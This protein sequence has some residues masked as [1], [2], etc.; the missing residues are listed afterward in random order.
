MDNQVWFDGKVHWNGYAGGRRIMST[1]KKVFMS[2]RKVKKDYGYRNLKGRKNTLDWR[3]KYPLRWFEWLM[4]PASQKS[5]KHFRPFDVTRK[6]FYYACSRI[7]GFSRRKNIYV[8]SI[9]IKR[10]TDP[11][12]E[13]LSRQQTASW[14]QLA[15]C[16]EL[17]SSIIDWLNIEWEKA[18]NGG[19]PEKCDN[20]HFE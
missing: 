9:S 6:L 1:S 16:K 19:L 14:W 13:G 4:Q 12:L 18:N 2:H 17:A 15:I 11:D 10:C 7:S 3:S 20:S 8:T 5:L